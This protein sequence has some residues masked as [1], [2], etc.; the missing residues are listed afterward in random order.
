MLVGGDDVARGAHAPHERA[1]VQAA[2]NCIV[3]GAVA[4]T[5]FASGGIE[6]TGGW[7]ALNV[8]VLPPTAI[9]AV[10]VIWHWSARAR[11]APARAQ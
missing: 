8:V 10:L 7:E 11:L 2:N 3:I 9:A 6:A 1:R 4:C 5:A